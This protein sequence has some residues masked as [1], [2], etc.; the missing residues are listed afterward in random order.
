MKKVLRR[1]FFI[2]CL[3]LTLSLFA[4]SSGGSDVNSGSDNNNN[5]DSGN[6]TG[7]NDN[8][9]I[10]APTLKRLYILT[11]S[12]RGLLTR[13]TSLSSDLK[14]DIED[15]VSIEVEP[16]DEEDK[17]YVT[18]NETFTVVAELNNPDDCEI[19]S[20]TVNGQNYA[21]NSFKSESNLDRILLDVTAPATSG[22][23]DYSLEAIKYS[24][25]NV[26]KDI[27]IDSEKATISAGIKYVTEP[28]V[29]ISNKEI[30]PTSIAFDVELNDQTNIIGNNEKKAFLSDGENIIKTLD[31]R[32][33]SNHIE[34]NNLKT[35]TTYQY[36]IMTA[37]D[38]ID[39]ANIQ[40]RTLA[41]ETLKTL[42]AINIV[43][44][45]VNEDGVSFDIE[46]ISSIGEVM[47]IS[48][49]DV[50]NDYSLVETLTNITDREFNNLLSN[51]QYAIKVVYRYFLDD[52]ENISEVNY[53][54]RTN[55]V[56]A[57]KVN[58]KNVT[59]TNTSIN[60][61]IEVDDQT[62]TYFFDRVELYQ[63]ETLVATNNSLTNNE[64]TDLLSN[65]EYSMKL[66]YK[67]DLNDGAGQQTTS[68]SYQVFTKAKKAPKV[69][70]QDVVSTENSISFA[71]NI[72]DEYSLYKFVM[73]ELFKGEELV[74]RTD[75]ASV[76]EFKDLLSNTEYTIKL[77]Y[78]YDLNDGEGLQAKTIALTVTTKAKQAP[79]VDVVLNVTSNSLSGRVEVVAQVAVNIVAINLYLDDEIIAT[80]KDEVFVFTVLPNVNYRLEVIYEYNLEDGNGNIISTIEKEIISGKQRP[81]I[82]I[83]EVIP[84]TNNVEFDYLINDP[85][86]TGS[87]SSIQVKKDNQIIFESSETIYS[88]DGLERNTEYILVIVYTYD[89]GDGLGKKVI[90]D[91][92]AFCTLKQTP[93]IDISLTATE[94]SIIV[95]PIIVDIDNTGFVSMVE[96]YLDDELIKTSTDNFIFDD[97]L[98]N[99]LYKIVL[100]YTYDVNNG[101]ITIY[102]E[103]T[104]TTKRAETPIVTMMLES[105]ATS[106]L[107]DFRVADDNNVF[108]FVVLELFEGDTLVRSVDVFAEEILLEGLLSNK[109]YTVRLTYT[110]DLNDGNGSQTKEVESSISTKQISVPVVDVVTSSTKNSLSFDILIEDADDVYRFDKVELYFNDQLIKTITTDQI[111]EFTDLLSNNYYTLIV[112]YHYD[113]ND[114]LGIQEMMVTKEVA[115]LEKNEPNVTFTSIDTDISS[116]YFDLTIIDDDLTIYEINVSLYH[117][118]TLLKSL[119]DWEVRMFSNLSAS[120]SYTIR[121]VYVYDLNDGNGKITR[122][123]LKIIDMSDGNVEADKDDILIYSLVETTTP[124]ESRD[125][126][127][128]V[129]GES[130]RIL[131]YA[132]W[133]K[134][135]SDDYDLVKSFTINVEMSMYS[136]VL[137]AN[138]IIYKRNKISS[139]TP[140]SQSSIDSRLDYDI[141]NYEFFPE[142]VGTISASASGKGLNIE[143]LGGQDTSLGGYNSISM[144]EPVLLGIV[145]Y[146]IKN[147]AKCK[148]IILNNTNISIYGKNYN[149][150]MVDSVIQDISETKIMVYSS[151][152]DSELETLTIN[153]LPVSPNLTSGLYEYN[154]D[155]PSSIATL[156]AVVRGGGSVSSVRVNGKVI[157]LTNGTYTFQLGS[158]ESLTDV[159]ISTKSLDGNSVTKYTIVIKRVADIRAKLDGLSFEAIGSLVGNDSTVLYNLENTKTVSFSSNIYEYTLRISSDVRKIMFVPTFQAYMNVYFQGELLSNGDKISL[160]PNLSDSIEVLVVSPSGGE[161]NYQIKIDI[162]TPDLDIKSYSFVNAESNETIT[163]EEDGIIYTSNVKIPFSQTD[164]IGSL[165]FA[166]GTLAI[167]DGTPYNSG[168]D[169]IFVFEKHQ[170]VMEIVLTLSSEF[171]SQKTVTFIIERNQPSADEAILELSL[172]GMVG[173]STNILNYTIDGKTYSISE[174]I[175]FETTK[176]KAHM[177]LA[178]NTAYVEYLGDRYYNGLDG[179]VIVFELATDEN[180]FELS[181]VVCADD[182]TKATYIILVER[183]IP[184]DDINL[185]CELETNS[186]SI[187]GNQVSIDGGTRVDFLVPYSIS[188]ATLVLLAHEKSLVYYGK[189]IN[190]MDLYISP[191]I[192]TIDQQETLRYVKVV[193]ESGV[194]HLYTL[195]VTKDIYRS[196][197]NKLLNLDIVDDEQ[198]IVFNQD[199][200]DYSLVVPYS[201]TDVCFSAEISDKASFVSDKTQVGLLYRL[202]V[203][204]N[205][206]RFQV[207]AESGL[208]SEIYTVHIYREDGLS[209]NDITEL[210][211]NDVV[212][213]EFESSKLIYD[214]VYDRS[215][216]NVK[217]DVVVSEGAE[218]VVREGSVVD[219]LPGTKTVVHIDVTS[220]TSVTKTYVVNVY[221]AS[222][223]AA[224]TDIQ[225]LSA[226]FGATIEDINAKEFSFDKDTLSYTFVVPYYVDRVYVDV[227]LDNIYAKVNMNNGPEIELEFGI[228]ESVE[229]YALSEYAILNPAVEVETQTYTII[230]IREEASKEAYLNDLSF[231]V[232]G[233]D[234]IEDFNSSTTV[235]EIN[236]AEASTVGSI[237]VVIGEGVISA[238]S[239]LNFVE[240][241]EGLNIYTIIVNS[242]DGNTSITYTI[243]VNRI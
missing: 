99:R 179:L 53:E 29:V 87:I 41:K 208:L 120:K 4:C 115:T 50:E 101:E 233:I 192:I 182:G 156:K 232:D 215:L 184:S 88:I 104:I 241:E 28:T 196:D 65:V 228:S 119:S 202:S 227:L 172:Y 84:G 231:V 190:A 2:F 16:N 226:R 112:Y 133:G 124:G 73:L 217:I 70:Y 131:F 34:F 189:D 31:L 167:I 194:E 1:L 174:S 216:K 89:M 176:I 63:G 206:Y 109:C 66:I 49:Y 45:V 162:R 107:V 243:K 146:K 61:E 118:T 11:S 157:G 38:L 43:N 33:G 155:V 175:S 236:L 201:I 195:I 67:Y 8:V 117:E 171:G 71:L 13:T 220:Q 145:E 6:N 239:D 199:L 57:P 197:E 165:T 123:E 163:F 137:E 132:Q 116:I 154:I 58:F 144:A 177:D 26:I 180:L 7:D 207:Q 164:V 98:S 234:Y 198:L 148:E 161:K 219:L 205:E 91:E 94:T 59:S 242:E 77:T 114:G 130:F 32:V 20:I 21:K 90:Q 110:Y 160:N 235:Y 126:N 62:G 79:S 147:D 85:N 44:P 100:Y 72:Q 211:I 64:F 40:S 54:F 92:M 152:N 129:P 102:D 237:S 142:A 173:E 140:G 229:L 134:D 81:T 181:F 223:D 203:G 125:N 82:N 78:A 166:S 186:I 108:K 97:L 221:T 103:D 22:Y 113:I 188:E 24:D 225:I 149:G 224:V 193:A 138:P 25:G 18:A 187:I 96:L 39:G 153:D 222:Q 105:T 151:S 159:V 218:Y 135:P 240:I 93:S 143:Q 139:S 3:I 68:L 150:T 185:E 141:S 12:T 95:E 36:A 46:Q 9:A 106:V 75:L 30:T 230:I 27:E 122:S 191:I 128:F 212:Q 214:V 35:S 213:T 204:Y 158:I 111:C 83:Q 5:G 48:L 210:K 76:R 19:Q 51:H 86:G 17:Y 52:I 42:S 60:Y 169:R 14:N 121:L 10:V 80:T 127:I 15:L 178:S 47:S 37:Y 56:E 209:G 136:T 200:Y 183:L 55:T 23:Y 74:E 69:D 170:Y 238:N 168:T